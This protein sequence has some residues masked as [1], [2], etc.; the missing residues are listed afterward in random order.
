MPPATSPPQYAPVLPLSL[1]C[2]PPSLEVEEVGV[3]VAV[4]HRAAPVRLLVIDQLAAV[5]AL[6]RTEQGAADWM[7]LDDMELWEMLR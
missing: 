4:V 6:C 7:K 2:S 3:V 5:L 1:P